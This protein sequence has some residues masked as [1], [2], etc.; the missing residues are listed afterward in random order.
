MVGLLPL[1][2]QLTRR[3]PFAT[4]LVVDIFVVGHACSHHLFLNGLRY[5]M[6]HGYANVP[7]HRLNGR[8]PP[9]RGQEQTD[10]ILP[11]SVVGPTSTKFM[12]IGG[13]RFREKVWQNG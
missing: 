13:A 1:A 11:K 8:F 9:S 6:Q 4:I 10:C 12:H 2:L 7:S 5:A 3:N